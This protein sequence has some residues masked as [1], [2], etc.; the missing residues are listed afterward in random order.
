[1]V[2]LFLYKFYVLYIK[3]SHV[4]NEFVVLRL[5]SSSYFCRHCR[6]YVGYTALHQLTVHANMLHT[7]RSLCELNHCILHTWESSE[8][9]DLQILYT[10]SIFSQFFEIIIHLYV[11]GCSHV[12]FYC[13]ISQPIYKI[14][15]HFFT[16]LGAFLS[17]F[18]STLFF[19]RCFVN[20]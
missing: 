7:C 16:P 10:P 19:C 6:N 1:M 5:V 13:F 18:Q 9:F 20:H 14:S 12:L 17:Y 4:P 15:K 2:V 3:L 8:Y 11:S